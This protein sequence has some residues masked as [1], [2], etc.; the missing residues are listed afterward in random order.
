MEQ[1]LSGLNFPNLT[2]KGSKN[3]HLGIFSTSE[4]FLVYT[5]Y[6]RGGGP[7]KLRMVDEH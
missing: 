5:G 1:L 4:H 7:L 2:S 6:K 3:G